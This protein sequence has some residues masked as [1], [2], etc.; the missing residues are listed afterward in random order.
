MPAV[1]D[2]PT[3]QLITLSK[4]YRPRVGSRAVHRARLLTQLDVAAGLVVVIA[5]AGYG[6]TTLLSTWLETCTLPSAWLSLDDQD[7][8]LIL[9]GLYLTAAVRTLFPAACQDTLELLHGM[10]TPPADVI[11]RSL[12]NDLSALP[13]EFILVLDDYHV[14]HNPDDSHSHG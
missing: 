10:T 12:S 2:S 1:P 9:F 3:A 14:I 7:D 13:H 8:D 6:K 5:P 11:S 4:L